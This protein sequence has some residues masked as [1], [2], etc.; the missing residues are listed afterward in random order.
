[1]YEVLILRVAYPMRANVSFVVLCKPYQK[2]EA[3]KVD[4][5]I[6]YNSNLKPHWSDLEICATI[7]LSDKK[8]NERNGR[9]K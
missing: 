6:L 2:F 1:M 8:T 9:R 7:R 5:I 4:F 3:S